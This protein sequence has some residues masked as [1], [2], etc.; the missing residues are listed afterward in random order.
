MSKLP[1]GPMSS[2]PLVTVQLT[3]KARTG[4]TSGPLTPDRLE[5]GTDG[6]YVMLVVCRLSVNTTDPTGNDATAVPWFATC[7]VQLNGMVA[8]IVALFVFVAMRSELPDSVTVSLQ[9]LFVSPVPPWFVSAA[10]LFGSTWQMP[11]SRGLAYE[12]A[13]LGVPVIVMSK[14]PPAPITNGPLVTVQ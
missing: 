9:L 4:H 1:P 14:L 11:L 12:P 2:G 7:T 5:T 6:E 8:W 3:V 13:A 10:T